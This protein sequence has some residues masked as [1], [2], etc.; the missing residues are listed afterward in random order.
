MKRCSASASSRAQGSVAATAVSLLGF[1]FCACDGSGAAAQCAMDIESTLTEHISFGKEIQKQIPKD[2]YNAAIS[3]P[4]C[5]D[6]AGERRC[7]G[8]PCWCCSTNHGRFNQTSQCLLTVLLLLPDP[9]D[10]SFLWVLLLFSFL[11]NSL[12]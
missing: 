3:F 5:V 8:V 6:E 9:D 2:S 12:H 1:I 10:Y 7:R 4:F 11:F